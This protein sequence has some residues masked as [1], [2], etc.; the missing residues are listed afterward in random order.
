MNADK[1]HL[2]GDTGPSAETEE[3]LQW[4]REARGEREL[5]LEVAS[6]VRRRRVRL[7][8]ASFGAAAIVA[9]F[10]LWPKARLAPTQSPAGPLT[11]IVSAPERRV[12]DDGSVVELRDGAQI[13]V[14]YSAEFRRV[15]LKNGQALFEVAKSN[16]RPFI[17]QAAGVEVRAVGTAFA[18]DRGT[19]QV[20][21]LVT[22]GRVAVDRS[23]LGPATASSST[24]QPATLAFVDAGKR[25]VVDIS[26]DHRLS[27]EVSDVSE[28]EMAESLSW[29]IPQLELS[30]TPL[31]EAVALMNARNRTQF[32]VADESLQDVKLSGYLRAD[33]IDGLVR[34]LEMNFGIK[35]E[36]RGGQILLRR[37][38]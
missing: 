1:Y 19:N 3:A 13:T 25:L 23:R 18:V 8:A 38:P 37:A 20:E 28:S 17:V 4:L 5:V 22:E 31:K 16:A 35:A 15:E 32:V 30:R 36:R 26:A 34:L 12:L 9:S 33:N 11:A 6:S 10:L 7:A 14:E 21:V 24:I 29:R 2:K 27:R